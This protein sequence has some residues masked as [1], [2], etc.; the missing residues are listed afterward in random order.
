MAQRR[1]AV[2]GGGIAG[3]TAALS[4]QDYGFEATVYEASGRVGGRMHS[5]SDPWLGDHRTDWCAELVNSTHTTMRALI[6]RAKVPVLDR[7]RLLA[8][9]GTD[10]YLLDGERYS[11]SEAAADW[12]RV[13]D[14]AARQV[15][16]L[17]LPIRGSSPPALAHE[18]DQMSVHDWIEA[19][20]AGGLESRLGA[21]L[22][23][24]Y[25]IECG[26]DARK[27]SA[28]NL[29][30]QVTGQPHP[31]HFHVL[32]DSDERFRV[33]GGADQLPKAIALLLPEHAI[34]LRTR[35]TRLARADDGSAELAFDSEDG[36][37]GAGY[38]A[39]ILAVPFTILRQL[40]FA[41][42]GFDEAKT[43]AIT[44]LGYGAHT[45]LQLE[46]RGK[47]WLAAGPFSCDGTTFT[48]RL[49]QASWE[50]SLGDRDESTSVLV[51][52]LGGPEA[53]RR[54]LAVPY[55]TQ[56]TTGVAA[57]AEQVVADL[58]HVWPGSA[59][60][61]CGRATMTSAS[62]DPNLGASYSAR[63]VGQFTGFAD[64]D[65]APAPPFFFAGEH[66]CPDFQRFMEGAARSGIQAAKDLAAALA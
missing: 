18:L 10:L 4:L 19:Y 28:I 53:E 5:T 54:Q 40:D 24:G 50:A 21:L 38:D 52:Y 60:A 27:L 58:A 66:C 11:M 45:K 59:E 33:V 15:A 23:L 57:F 61:F 3:L 43:C 47:P 36:G 29:L 63:L 64:S 2:I 6:R 22:A 49:F 39:V 9:M 17:G 16:A 41:D 62:S 25:R 35:L 31:D 34:R 12:A 65:R 37:M 51:V 46:Y 42:A 13:K 44:E 30:R 55:A 26:I 14:L 20:V 8:C 32:G 7:S 56:E 1:V 48:D